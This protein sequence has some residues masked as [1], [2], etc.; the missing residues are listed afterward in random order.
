MRCSDRATE[1]LAGSRPPDVPGARATAGYEVRLQPR[2]LQHGVGASHRAVG[3]QFKGLRCILGCFNLKGSHCYWY[4]SFPSLPVHSNFYVNLSTPKSPTL[5]SHPR[6]LTPRHS[7]P[8]RVTSFALPGWLVRFHVQPTAH[9]S[10][11][12][13]AKRMTFSSLS[14]RKTLAAASDALRG[15]LSHKTWHCHI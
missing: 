14:A 15:T 11:S 13:A 3:N 2:R 6:L 12:Y 8:I 10:A 7:P 9:K 5:V 1:L 4:T